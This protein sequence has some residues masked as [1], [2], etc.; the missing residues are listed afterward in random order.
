MLKSQYSGRC[1]GK[2]LKPFAKLMGGEAGAKRGER[3]LRLAQHAAE[4]A[5][6][7]L[8]PAD[9]SLAPEGLRKIELHRIGAAVEHHLPADRRPGEAPL[10]ELRSSNP[11]AVISIA[12]PRSLAMRQ[13]SPAIT[14]PAA[15]KTSPMRMSTAAPPF[16]DGPRRLSPPGRK[17][18]PNAHFRQPEQQ[19]QPG[20]MGP[21]GNDH[22]FGHY[23]ATRPF[24]GL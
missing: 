3:E 23:G 5:E 1:R 20:E 15:V 17:Q 11:S 9:C 21:V 4:Q 24:P 18:Q 8:R 16:S 13:H 14:T 12:A 7:P 2:S 19:Q 6:R 10:T 22:G